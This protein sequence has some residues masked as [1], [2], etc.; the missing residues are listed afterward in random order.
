MLPDM[1]SGWVG[2][3]AAFEAG[4]WQRRPALFHPQGPDPRSLPTMEEVDA[5]LAAGLLH[6][7][8]AEL[9]DQDG[10]VPRE[11]YCRSR[12]VNGSTLD[13]YADGARIGKLVQDGA[14]LLLNCVDHWHSGVAELTAALTAGLGRS[15]DAALFATRPG[16]QGLGLHVDDGDVFLLQLCGSK[17]WQVHQG[18]A[19]GD[20]HTGA[21]TDVPPLVLETTVH[22]G[23]ALYI[24]RGVPHRA[25]AGDDGL[26]AHISV[27]VHEIGTAHLY[28]ALHNLLLDGVDLRSKPL[29]DTALREGAQALLRSLAQRLDGIGP[30]ELVV[31]ARGLLAGTA[32]RTPSSPGLAALV[33]AERPEADIPVVA[34]A[35]YQPHTG[36]PQ[37]PLH[38]Q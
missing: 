24:P 11:A 35:P 8:Y 31:A 37:S 17:H 10:P 20:W 23:D 21:L 28:A 32:P 5:V 38:D 22:A 29:G 13:G 7:K 19:D 34:V 26:S 25:A 9:M 18:P 6:G 2:D 14:T 15:T 3:V 4:D 33:G 30:E 12:W 36:R 1:L 27:F 16:T